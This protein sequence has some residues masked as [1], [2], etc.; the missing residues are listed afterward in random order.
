MIDVRR[1]FVLFISVLLVVYISYMGNDKKE[2][3]WETKDIFKKELQKEFGE[4]II[5][6]RDSSQTSALMFF[7]FDRADKKTLS[8]FVVSLGFFPMKE[9]NNEFCLR[10][11]YIRIFYLENNYRLMYVYPDE[12]C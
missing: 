10:K 1:I 9:S 12:Q 8:N 3:S 6:I 4:K 5:R 11:Q 7:E 2:I